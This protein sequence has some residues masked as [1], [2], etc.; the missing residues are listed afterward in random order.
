MRRAS[1]TWCLTM[2]LVA[3]NTACGST[4]DDEGGSGG[5]FQGRLCAEGATCSAGATCKFGGVESSVD[6]NCDP[7]GH[8]FCDASSYGGAPPFVACSEQTA[9]SAGAGTKECV[10]SNGYC[11]RSCTCNGT[12]A[13]ECTGSGPAQGYAGAVCNLSYCG[14]SPIQRSCSVHDGTC[15]YSVE[16]GEKQTLTGSCP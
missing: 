6:C 1:W 8:F 2:G 15:S 5:A 12:C 16:C 9:C 10:Q 4:A 11:T 14:D 3:G 13:T 7:S